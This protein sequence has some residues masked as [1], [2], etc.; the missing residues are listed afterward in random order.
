MRPLAV[1]AL[2]VPVAAAAAPVPTPSERELIAKHWGRP[3][4][5]GEFALTGGRLTL[6]A[7][8]ASPAGLLR[9]GRTVRG[10]FTAEVTVGAADCPDPAKGDAREPHSH[11]GL[12]VAG[13]GYTVRLHLMQQYNR[14][15]GA[16][17]QA[18]PQRCVWLDRWHPRG[19]S[20][21]YLKEAAAGHAVR[22]R[23]ARTGKAVTAAFSFDGKGWAETAVE[24]EKAALPDEVSVAVFLAHDTRQQLSATFER[25]AVEKPKE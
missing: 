17:L 8:G 15:D 22:L 1:L 2:L 21:S 11:A 14:G 23:V 18:E 13:G 4:G 6:R 19:G 3:E 10:D 7:V 16:R 24:A 5:D 12:S 25:F 9:V 20:G